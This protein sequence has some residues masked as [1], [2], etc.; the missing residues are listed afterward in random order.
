MLGADTPQAKRDF[1]SWTGS[2]GVFASGSSLLE[3]KAGISIDSKDPSLSKAAVPKLAAA[4]RAK[5]ATLA[6]ASVP[7]AEAAAGAHVSG[8]PL[9]L[10]I[11]AGRDSSGQAK[12]VIGLGEASAAEALNPSSTLGNA[13]SHQAAETTLGES[14]QPNVM[15]DFPT[16]LSLLE[17]IGLT[18]DPT[19]APVLPYLHAATTLDG[20]GHELSDEMDRYRLVLGLS[21][22]GG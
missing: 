19:L 10:V 21:Q 13:P 22:S 11:A 15:L 2:A 3:L 9:E 1:A 5:G 8:L 17:G 18:S 12:L 6:A 7:G 14:T 20:G 4:L 16:L